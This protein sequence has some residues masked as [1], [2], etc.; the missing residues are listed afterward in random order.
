MT[1]RALLVWLAAIAFAVSPFLNPEFGG[2][3]PDRYPI[4][5]IDPPVQPAGYA[6]AIWGVIYL[7]L[8]GH[9]SWGLFRAAGDAQWDA[10]RLWEI[11]TLGVGAAWLPVALVSPVWATVMIWGMLLTALRATYLAQPGRP[12]WGLQLPLGLYAGW[13]TAASWVSVGLLG[14]GY[15][16][17]LGETGWAVA[18]LSA[19]LVMA[20]LMQL[21]LR[22][23]WTYGLAV[24]WGFAGIAVSNMGE[25]TWLAGLAGVAALLMLGLALR[26]G[27][28]PGLR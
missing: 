25:T 11:V 24:A 2:F 12:R 22:R 9:A 1:I 10:P 18:A 14:A 21:A 13:L 17:A 16:L 3:D 28:N 20:I 8:L 4:P 19:G 23:V 26:A 6:F 5:Q 27:I 15:G 7:W